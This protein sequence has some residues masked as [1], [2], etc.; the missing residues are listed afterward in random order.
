[1]SFMKNATIPTPDTF[2]SGLLRHS[3][4]LFVATQVGNL[5]TLLFQFVMMRK[6]PVAEYGI[7]ASMLSIVLIMGTPMEALRSAVAHQTS[8]LLR[9]GKKSAVP[10]FLSIWGRTL[11]LA[12]GVLSISGFIF[13]AHIASLFHL[14]TSSLVWLT[15]LIVAGSLFMPFFAGALQG[16]QSFVWLA[17]HGQVWGVVRLVSAIILLSCLANTAMTGLWAQALGVVAS[18]GIGLFA[19]WR[20]L[21]RTALDST[22]PFVGWTYF[23][24][25]LLVLSGYAVIMNVDVALVRIFFTPE[26]AGYYARAATIGRTIVFL[27]VPV[28][29]VM[30]PK[31][32]STGISSAID[33]TILLKAVFLTA[34][35]I[36][37]AGG[38]FSWFAGPVWWFFTG[39]TADAEAIRLIRLVIWALAPL[40]LTFLLLN[41]EIAQHRFRAPSILVILAMVYIVAVA[42]RHDTLEQVIGVLAVISLSSLL[43][44]GSDMLRTIVL[45]GRRAR[46]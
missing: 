17:V 12:A 19:L 36:G 37:A 3:M 35:L 22:E 28:A 10:R 26:E 6:L 34:A 23:F 45:G 44:L 1:M 14:P 16:M 25:S 4:L 24:W 15:S 40:G 18:I 39:E 13:S 21:P 43:L 33:R 31:V 46:I 32:V 7:L 30:F 42:L 9:Q 5:A 27:P 20:M 41:F 11:L 2:Q 29:M 8:W 38:I